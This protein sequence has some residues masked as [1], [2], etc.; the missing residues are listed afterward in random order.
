MFEHLFPGRNL[1]ALFDRL[2]IRRMGTTIGAESWHRDVGQKEPGDIIYGG[3]VNLDP[4]GTPPQ[5]FSCVPGDVLPPDVDPLGFAKFAKEDYPQLNQAF[6]ASGGPISI[7]PGH[8]IL[9][10]Q[11]IAHKITG[12][13]AKRTSMRL[14]MG[15]RITTSTIPLY[16]KAAIITA[17]AVPPLPS[18]QPAPMYAKLHWVNWKDRLQEF[19]TGFKPGCLDAKRPGFV[20]REL[21]SLTAL[22][23]G[24]RAYTPA[25]SAIFYPQR[26]AP[27]VE[28]ADAVEPPAKKHKSST[29]PF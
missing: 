18:G 1:E 14:Y 7:P 2:S 12:A 10:D 9:F 29:F 15:W 4:P 3:W 17:Q 16:D 22:G 28:K 19:S 24:F 8:V 5:Q 23:F 26:L 6:K 20:A 11:T 27:I 25:E 21:P 13:K